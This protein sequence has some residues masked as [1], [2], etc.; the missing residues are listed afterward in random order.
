MSFKYDLDLENAA[1]IFIAL[2]DPD[3]RVLLDTIRES[4]NL[5]KKSLL[6][7][8]GNK[9]V[10]LSCLSE[11]ELE[12]NLKLLE[13]AKL[14]RTYKKDDINFCGIDKRGEGIDQNYEVVS[15]IFYLLGGDFTQSEALLR[16]RFQI[17]KFLNYDEGGKTLAQ[18]S[19]K[20]G[21]SREQL[22]IHLSAV[23]GVG[24]DE[25]TKKYH[26]ASLP[27]DIRWS[28]FLNAIYG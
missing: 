21:I 9:N 17:L 12:K 23:Q 5:T 13:D 15:K 7:L 14:I 24:Y 2:F 4:K 19:K 6:P 22:Q 26:T 20:L 8:L 10:S 1:D 28:F 25:K 3:R 18:L 16:T 27:R 11:R